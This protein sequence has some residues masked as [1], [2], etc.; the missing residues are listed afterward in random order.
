MGSIIIFYMW[1]NIATESTFQMNFN[2]GFSNTKSDI[3]IHLS[4]WQYWWWFWF[5]FLWSLYFMIIIRVVRFRTLKFQPR[6]V[7]S[8]RPHG[9]WGD[10]LVCLI[11]TMWCANILINSSF[12]L[13]LIEWQNESSLFTVRIRGRQWYW[14]YKYD[15]KD[16][17]DI[18]SA[19]KN[20]G[21]NKWFNSTN[22]S[23]DSIDDY[24]R[25]IQ[26]R[27]ANVWLKKYWDVSLKL[28][29]KENYEAVTS[30][31]DINTQS[32]NS[33]FSTVSY[34][35]FDESLRWI[36]R[37]FGANAPVKIIKSA[38][39]EDALFKCRFSNSSTAVHKN[40]TYNPFLVIKQKR[41]TL[42]KKILE[43]NF[44]NHNLSSSKNTIKSNFF[45]NS[46][47]SENTK[48]NLSKV[49]KFF[50]KNKKR[51]EFFN[52]T[53]SRRLLRTRHTLVL[54]AHVN[55]TAIT[56]SYDVVHSWFIPGL[57]L[58]MDCIPGRATHH[59]FYAD[60]VGF[61]YGQ[62]AEICGR[63][64]HHMP[65]RVCVL[66]YE[67]FLLWWHHFGLPKIL[68]AGKNKHLNNSL[69]FRKYVW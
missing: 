26:V 32:D 6:I 51:D 28:Q 59:T 36:K 23:Y 10:L 61:Y 67:Q 34:S 64:H 24:L 35:N 33:N 62:C 60:N 55:I 3:L 2:V 9:K 68:Y 4:Q 50:K 57:G 56:N 45:L 15:L 58:K 12:L 11:P 42:K 19:S 44:Y 49:Y 43:K 40:I 37:S 31:V 66:P 65:I 16:V 22:G 1:G 53:T 30:V 41:Y 29:A 8:F 46:G 69:F 38:H 21:H 63:Y 25:L 52:I 54:P 27:A 48:D 20:V 14:V 47:V 18:L 7:T 13:K 5:V 17:S 39:L